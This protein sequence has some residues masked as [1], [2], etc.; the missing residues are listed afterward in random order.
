MGQEAVQYIGGLCL[1]FTA[2]FIGLEQCSPYESIS[3]AGKQGDRIFIMK[4]FYTRPF[5]RSQVHDL[6]KI[7]CF[8]DIFFRMLILLQKLNSQETGRNTVSYPEII[9][10]L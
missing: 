7:P 9:R 5:L 4:L 1:L 10:D 2:F 8:P 3:F 6:V